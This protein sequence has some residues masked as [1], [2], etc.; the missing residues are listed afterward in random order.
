[1]RKCEKDDEKNCPIDICIETCAILGH[2]K[3]IHGDD[4]EE[5]WIEFIEWFKKRQV[6]EMNRVLEELSYYRNEKL[7]EE[8]R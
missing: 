5:H 8:R 6:T 7:K 3:P 2:K 1:M 4:T